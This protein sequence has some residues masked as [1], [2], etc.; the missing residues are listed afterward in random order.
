MTRFGL[1]RYL[2]FS[3]LILALG[4]SLMLVGLLLI[5]Y[6]PGL[7]GADGRRIGS[8]LAGCGIAVAASILGGFPILFVS[9]DTSPPV[10]ATLAM[11]SMASRF[12]IA[13]GL[14]LVAAK[15]ERFVLTP[16]MA[17]LATG[18]LS[19]LIPDTLYATRT[20]Q[21]SLEESDRE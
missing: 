17:W 8:M 4:I 1:A 21:H 7:G 15:S 19:L 16:L 2:R 10:A 5:N 13:L 18:Y 14:G 12:L 3:G 9:T 11:V 6:M 20:L